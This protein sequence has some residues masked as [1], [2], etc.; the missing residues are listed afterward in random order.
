[1]CRTLFVAGLHR[2]GNRYLWESVYP[3][4]LFLDR[5]KSGS[6]KIQSRNKA[7][8]DAHGMF[9]WISAKP[10]ICIALPLSRDFPPFRKIDYN[11]SA[12]VSGVARSWLDGH[13]PEPQAVE[14][15]T[16]TDF[17]AFLYIALTFLFLYFWRSWE[18]DRHANY[19]YYGREV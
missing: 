6:F 13:M 2:L 12:W 3:D 7:T 17:H 19:Y 5:L 11:T 1:M 9:I 16:D 4:A 18:V 10:A 14:R 15:V 8:I